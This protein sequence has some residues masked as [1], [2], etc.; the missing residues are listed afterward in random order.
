MLIYLLS[1]SKTYVLEVRGDETI[2]DIEDIIVN[3]FN[4]QRSEFTLNFDSEIEVDEKNNNFGNIFIYKRMH[5]NG[6]CI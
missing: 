1:Q 5:Y 3:E 6:S 2:K 4:I